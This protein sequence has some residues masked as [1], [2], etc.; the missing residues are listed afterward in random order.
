M[1]M[2]SADVWRATRLVVDTGMHARGW[3][4]QQAVDYFLANTPVAPIEVEAEV[5]RYIALPAQ[6]LAYMTGR[7]QIQDLRARAEQELGPRF[8]IRAFH[9]V[10]LGSGGL[11]LAVLSDLV[12]EW[13]AAPSPA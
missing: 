6:A 5:D 12:T 7:I 9:D 3:S 10:V 1:G 13:I 4:R 11:P 2:L 8:D